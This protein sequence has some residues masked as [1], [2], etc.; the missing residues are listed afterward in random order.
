MMCHHIALLSFALLPK[1]IQAQ[2][3]P[4]SLIL[5]INHE[6]LSCPLLQQVLNVAWDCGLSVAGQNAD[7]CFDRGEHIRMVETSKPRNDPD[8]RHFSF[9]VYQLPSPFVQR[10]YCFT[11]LNYF[12]KSMHG[13]YSLYSSQ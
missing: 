5:V 10:T 11:E 13:K 7:P 9:F 3:I 6:K 12:I 8:Q 1:D 2:F 4:L